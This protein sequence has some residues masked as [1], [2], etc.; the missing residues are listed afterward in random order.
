MCRY[1]LN[2]CLVPSYTASVTAILFT[3]LAKGTALY[4]LNYCDMKTYGELR[5]NSTYSQASCSG[6][7]SLGE[8][9]TGTLWGAR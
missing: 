9:E 8:R 1:Q 2:F 5:Y 6:C 4:V 3:V 7:C